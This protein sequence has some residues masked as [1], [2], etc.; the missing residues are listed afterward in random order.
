ML[1]LFDFSSLL[2]VVIAFY[3]VYAITSKNTQNTFVFSFIYESLK[4]LKEKSDKQLQK[5][6]SEYDAIKTDESEIDKTKLSDAQKQLMKT[7]LMGAKQ[8]Y[9][10]A[11]SLNEGF[12]NMFKL[13]EGES[14]FSV[15]SV[16]MIALCVVLMVMG[17][18]DH[19]S[20][21]SVDEVSFMLIMVVAI[22]QLHCYIY[23]FSYRIRS[24]KYLTPTVIGH[25]AI[26]SICVAGTIY[27]FDDTIRPFGEY[28]DINV[29]MSIFAILVVT[30][31]IIILGR[32][33]MLYNKLNGILKHS[34]KSMEWAM[35]WFH[36]DVSNYKEKYHLDTNQIRSNE[37]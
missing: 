26:M 6:K 4:K 22:L 34:G 24:I 10:I 19:K 27:C 32:H 18:L 21:W 17:V 25:L 2:Q 9:D 12:N 16:D 8:E 23:E 11:S 35:K 28:G 37:E 13:Y 33:Y 14:F 15:L 7:S 5:A 3:C 30:P 20:V 1:E 36:R 31:P 29:Y